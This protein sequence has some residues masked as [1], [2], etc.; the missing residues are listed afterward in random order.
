MA[1]PAT[2]HHIIITGETNLNRS[3]MAYYT[4]QTQ[5]IPYTILLIAGLTFPAINS[6]TNYIFITDL[7]TRIPVN[8]QNQSV[9]LCKSLVCM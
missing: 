3:N 5:P 2:I 6:T 4:Q 1:T 9:I 7:L 8:I